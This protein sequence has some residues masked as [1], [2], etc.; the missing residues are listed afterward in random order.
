MSWT[1]LGGTGGDVRSG[2]ASPRNVVPPALGKPQTR[3][4]SQLEGQRGMW[5]EAEALDPRGAAR[6]LA[7]AEITVT[8]MVRNRGTDTKCWQ[9]HAG[10]RRLCDEVR[11]VVRWYADRVRRCGHERDTTE[12]RRL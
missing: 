11:R 1:C 10:A 7:G 2:S 3:K 6:S 12:P 8:A 9:C 5:A 4:R